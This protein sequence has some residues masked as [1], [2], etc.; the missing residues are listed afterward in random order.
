MPGNVLMVA[1][2]QG[3]QGVDKGADSIQVKSELQ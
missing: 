3:R 1:I 2:L